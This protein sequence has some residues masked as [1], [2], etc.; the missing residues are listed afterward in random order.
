VNNE[1]VAPLP[2]SVDFG[3]VRAAKIKPFIVKFEK[4]GCEDRSLISAIGAAAGN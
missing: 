2:P 3:M 1:P 4:R